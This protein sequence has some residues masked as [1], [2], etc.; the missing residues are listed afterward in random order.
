MVPCVHPSTTYTHTH[1]TYNSLVIRQENYSPF[2]LP[3]AEDCGKRRQLKCFLYCRDGKRPGV[4][5]GFSRRKN[6]G[7][8]VSVIIGGASGF[9][10]PHDF[11]WKEQ[12]GVG[13][14][15]WL[16]A[17]LMMLLPLRE[18]EGIMGAEGKVSEMENRIWQKQVKRCTHTSKKYP[19]FTDLLPNK[20][21]LRECKHLH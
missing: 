17:F 8:R 4:F 14:C 15:C 21:A 12:R 16:I 5:F 19:S 9:K 10:V 13:N 1:T 18:T 11:G 3:G 6:K 20:K 2:C 7:D